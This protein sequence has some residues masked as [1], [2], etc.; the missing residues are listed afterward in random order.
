MFIIKKEQLLKTDIN[1]AW[2]FFSNPLNLSA[3]TPSWLNF[4]IVSDLPEKMYQGMIVEYR[5]H[6]FLSIPIK[7][8]TEITHINEPFFFVDEQRF[9]P[10]KFWH[11]KHFFREMNG[12][13]FMTDEVHY[14]L[15]FGIPGMIFNSIIVKNKLEEIFGYR[16]NTLEKIFNGVR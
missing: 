4:K 12:S 16:F 6:P 13:V 11:H 15:P 14:I 8:I 9:G 10:Y 5:V 2:D 7:W 1:S 3:I